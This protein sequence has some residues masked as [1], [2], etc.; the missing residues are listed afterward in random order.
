LGQGAPGALLR[1]TDLVYQWQKDSRYLTANMLDLLA[2]TV[3][4]S[5]VAASHIKSNCPVSGAGTLK[6]CMAGN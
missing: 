6:S 1:E 5:P 2:S 3:V 4:I